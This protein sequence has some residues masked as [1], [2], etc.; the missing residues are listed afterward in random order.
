MAGDAGGLLKL[1]KSGGVLRSPSVPESDVWVT[2]DLIRRHGLVQGA[3]VRGPVRIGQRGPELAAVDTVCGLKPEVF[4]KRA[5]FTQLTAIDPGE[6][7]RFDHADDNS[8][9]IVDLVAPVAKGTRGLIV[10]PPK[11]GKTILLEKLAKAIRAADPATRI[12]VFLVDERPEE[13]TYFRRTVQA[14]VFASSSDQKLKEHIDL[15]QLMLA[16]VRVELECGRD[17]V[18]LVDS[19]TRLVRAFNLQGGTGSRGRTLSGGLDAGAAAIPRQ[20]FGLARNVEHGGS[21]TILATILVDTGSRMDQVIFEEFK[22][23]GNS[24][25][26]LDRALAEARMFPAINIASSGTRKDERLYDPEDYR[27]V[28]KLRRMLLG[29]RSREAMA[30]M[31]KLMDRYANNADLLRNV[32]LEDL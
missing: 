21:V 26:V 22:G 27:R 1:G 10:A 7:Y 11:A 4:Q 25:I 16:H 30:L 14:E 6:R 2:A 5:P 28:V 13:V 32:P 9:R 8:P 19:F 18:V 29:Y 23:T 24:E 17:V 31:L 12:V 20:L 15:A 3:D